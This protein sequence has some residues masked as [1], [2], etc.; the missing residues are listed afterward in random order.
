MAKTYTELDRHRE[1]VAAS[2]LLDLLAALDTGQVHVGRGDD[3]ALALDG[4]DDVLG[5]AETRVGHG[6]GS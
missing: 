6:E 4:L 3:A 2:Q 1:E 5:E